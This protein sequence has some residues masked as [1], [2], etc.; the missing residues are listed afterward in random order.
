MSVAAVARYVVAAADHV[1]AAAVVVHG[2]AA[3]VVHDVAAEPVPVWHDVHPSF[4]PQHEPPLA[5]HGVHRFRV[6][7]FH[8]DV[9]FKEHIK[10]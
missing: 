7:C 5:F 6:H 9:P 3:V 2:V 4:F 1:A 10:I 8:H